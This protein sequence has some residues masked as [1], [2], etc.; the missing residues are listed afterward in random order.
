MC[1]FVVERDPS[2]C[3]RDHH[4][5]CVYFLFVCTRH[6]PSA[7]ATF[8][9]P[10]CKSV[11]SIVFVLFGIDDLK[12]SRGGAKSELK[13]SAREWERESR[14]KYILGEKFTCWFQVRDAAR[15]Q[16]HRRRRRRRWSWTIYCVCVFFGVRLPLW[17]TRICLWCWRCVENVV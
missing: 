5:K 4:R 8:C 1:I 14:E 16:Q 7:L 11:N 9:V 2:Y 10:P 12:R 17:F 13:L 6:N 3:C 15:L